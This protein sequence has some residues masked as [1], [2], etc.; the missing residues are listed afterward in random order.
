YG[1]ARATSSLEKQADRIA[2]RAVGGAQLRVEPSA[3]QL[4]AE[5]AKVPASV[6]QVLSSPGTPLDASVQA[7]LGQR[8]GHDFGR[9]RVHSGE[10]AARSAQDVHARASTVGDHVVSGAHRFEPATLEGRRLIAHELAL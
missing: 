4:V 3:G 5:S 7:E 10:A 9:V 8:I 1:T 2:D 6:E